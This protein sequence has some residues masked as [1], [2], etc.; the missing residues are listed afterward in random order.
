MAALPGGAGGRTSPQIRGTLLTLGGVLV[1]S[2]DAALVE[3]VGTE[4]ATMIFWR[5]VGAALVFSAVLFALRGRSLVGELRAGGATGL[6]IVACL[7]VS[8]LAWVTGVHLTNPAHVLVLVA[9]SPLFGAL[10]SRLLLGERIRPATVAAGLVAILAVA[11]T[12]SAS[13]RGSGG[14]LVGDLAGLVVAVVLGLGFTLIRRLGIPDAWPHFAV[15]GLLNAGLMAAFFPLVPVAPEAVPVLA[16]LVLVI[17]PAA[18]LLISLGPRLIPAPEVALLMLLEVPFGALFLW[19][20]AGRAATWE[21]LVGGTL[22]IATL[23]LHAVWVARHPR[24]A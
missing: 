21:S 1:L 16:F 18:F 22:L 14:D 19:L 9:T 12:V 23:G 11:I 10:F 4:T 6:G 2:P 8:Q 5:G 15:A 20:L 13:L 17:L 3:I 7:M 24:P